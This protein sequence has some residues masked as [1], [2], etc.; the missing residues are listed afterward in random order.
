MSSTNQSNKGLFSLCR[1][2]ANALTMPED[3]SI[4]VS[5]FTFLYSLTLGTDI[6]ECVGL[7]STLCNVL[8][9]FF[10]QKNPIS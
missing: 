4:F 7:L 3:L 9:I 6:E 10:L 5:N 1:I 8:K 2:A